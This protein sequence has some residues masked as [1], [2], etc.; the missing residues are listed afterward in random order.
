LKY[1]ITTAI[2]YTNAP[3]HIGHAYEKVF[4]DTIGRYHRLVD[5]AAFFLTGVDQHGQ[6]VQQAAQ[7]EGVAPMEFAQRVTDKFLELWNKLGI[8]KDGWAATTDP[9]HK[10][11]V[12]KV[13]QALYEKGEL[14]KAKY[15]GYYSVGQEQFLTDKDRNE[16]GEFGSEWGEIVFIEEENWYFQL[17]K[18][19]EWLREFVERHEDFVIPAFRRPELLNAIDRLGG[20]LCVSRPKERLSWGIEFPFDP[21]YVT[22]VW[23]DALLNYITFAG[24]LADPDAGLPNFKELWPCRGHIIGKDI[25]IPAHGIY[26]PIMLHAIGFSDD[27]MPR[28]V[29]HGWWNFSGAKMSKSVGNVVDPAL[30]VERLGADPI[31]YYLLRDMVIGQDADFSDDRLIARYNAELANDLGNLLN[32]TINMSQRYRSGVLRSTQISD[33]DLTSIRESAGMTITRY[34]QAFE[35]YQVHLALEAVRELVA[36]ANALVELKAPWKLAKEP[37]SAELLDGVLYALTETCRILALL[38]SPII[39]A[40]S[41]KMLAQLKAEN[42]NRLAWGELTTGHQIGSP[43]PVFPRIELSVEE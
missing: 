24:Y 32:R 26:W 22:Y 21:D 17:A 38:V 16:K 20:D 36:K 30:L 3:P 31:R 33:P 40:S 6:K 13:L 14:Y 37:A 10:R 7:K 4:A 25:L 41:T 23:F 8:Q 34:K 42:V 43:S 19:K 18:H 35:A 27:E 2:D 15:S 39:P 12:Q 29:V 5:G 28:L 11:A 1:F 9:R